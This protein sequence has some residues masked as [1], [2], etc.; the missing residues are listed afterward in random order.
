MQVSHCPQTLMLQ[1]VS[2]LHR[3]EITRNLPSATISSE[4]AHHFQHASINSITIKYACI[5]VIC[6]LLKLIGMNING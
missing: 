5:N 1:S 6:H 3:N 2:S 4:S